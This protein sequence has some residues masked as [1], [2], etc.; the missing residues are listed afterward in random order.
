MYGLD[1]IS[2]ESLVRKAVETYLAEKKIL[3]QER[4]DSVSTHQEYLTNEGSGSD[5]I[6]DTSTTPL[7]ALNPSS[8]VDLMMSSSDSA[9]PGSSVG[10]KGG[11]KEE[12][13]VSGSTG[14]GGLKEEEKRYTD[15]DGKKE[16]ESKKKEVEGD[17]GKI[18]VYDSAGE[19]MTAEISQEHLVLVSQNFCIKYFNFC[20]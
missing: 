4:R 3:D 2:L 10:G 8:S 19:S 5:T 6:R 13:K 7:I 12:G 1:I 18:K 17:S 11:S 20:T 15:S 14:K 16:A 9:M